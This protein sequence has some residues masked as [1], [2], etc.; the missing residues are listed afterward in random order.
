MPPPSETIYL[1]HYPTKGGPCNSQYVSDISRSLFISP[2]STWSSL[3]RNFKVPFFKFCKHLFFTVVA[4]L[5]YLVLAIHALI[6][7]FLVTVHQ[8]HGSLTENS[9]STADTYYAQ[10]YHSSTRSVPGLI[11]ASLPH[12]TSLRTVLICRTAAVSL[13]PSQ[14]RKW[15]WPVFLLIWIPDERHVTIQQHGCWRR[16]SVHQNAVTCTAYFFPLVIL[17]T[18]H[19]YTFNQRSPFCIIPLLTLARYLKAL[20]AQHRHSTLFYS[21]SAV[22]RHQAT[23]ETRWTII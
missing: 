2:F 20:G 9:C 11:I 14:L 6:L 5:S 3:S 16:S 18:T 1:V 8:R 10:E 19:W 7:P 22:V 23:A 4:S 15:L 13:L 12:R 21:V 17:A